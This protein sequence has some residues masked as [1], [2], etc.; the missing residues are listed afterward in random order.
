MVASLLLMA[1]SAYLL[2]TVSY[3]HMYGIGQASIYTQQALVL[4]ITLTH[5]A[6]T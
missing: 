2:Q 6:R 4:C 1:E 3:E 5:H